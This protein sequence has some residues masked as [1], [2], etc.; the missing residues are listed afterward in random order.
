MLMSGS[1]PEIPKMQPRNLHLAST[2]GVSDLGPHLKNY[3]IRIS[4]RATAFEWREV[5]DWMPTMSQPYTW[6]RFSTYLLSSPE[7][8]SEVPKR[9]S[10]I[11][12]SR[13]A[14]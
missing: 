12:P 14:K 2:P 11:S 3:K 5:T 4:S 7:Q 10:K 8:P 1:S 9:R 13:F 6:A